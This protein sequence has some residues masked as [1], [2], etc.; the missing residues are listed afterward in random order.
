MAERMENLEEHVEDNH[1]R[2]DRGVQEI[3][4]FWK[5]FGSKADEKTIAKYVSMVADGLHKEVGERPYTNRIE[6]EGEVLK[7][8]Y[9]SDDSLALKDAFDQLVGKF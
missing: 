5:V 2:I 8:V 9:Q 4:N 7:E 6:E 3:E 1:V